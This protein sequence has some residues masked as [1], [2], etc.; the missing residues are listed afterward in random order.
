MHD[1]ELAI[2]M[3]N[4]FCMDSEGACTPNRIFQ[5]NFI[6]DKFVGVAATSRVVGVVLLDLPFRLDF[7]WA[8]N[9]SI[10]RYEKENQY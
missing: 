8:C 4:I 7:K 10:W 3:E 6:D 9:F 1:I 5:D 2:D